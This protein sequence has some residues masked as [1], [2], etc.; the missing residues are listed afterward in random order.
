M[1]HYLYRKVITNFY[2]Y[3]TIFN[4]FLEKMIFFFLKRRFG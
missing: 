1:N 4:F 3:I 2:T